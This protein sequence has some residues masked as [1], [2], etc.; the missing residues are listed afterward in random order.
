MSRSISLQVYVPLEL[1]ERVRVAASA[2]DL[3]VSEWVRLLVLSAC[4]QE[5]LASTNT[6]LFERI[7]RQSL[8]SMVGV[9]ALLA[10]HPDH[11]L[12]TR[13]HEAF[14]RKLKE[15]GLASTVREGGSDEA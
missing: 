7:G 5:E 15:Q 4:E 2:R 14:S 8:F 6:R 12:R 9:D 13:V 10:G 3:S 1:A 11:A